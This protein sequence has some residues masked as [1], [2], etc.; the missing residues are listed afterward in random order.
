MKITVRLPAA[1]IQFLD[2]FAHSHRIG[3]RTDV[4]RLAVRRLRIASLGPAYEA[5]WQEWTEAES[6]AWNATIG[7][8]LAPE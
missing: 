3:S 5:A 6:E 2:E 4:I 7:D 8:G 1:D